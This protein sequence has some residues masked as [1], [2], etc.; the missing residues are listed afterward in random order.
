MEKK[1][2][3]FVITALLCMFPFLANATRMSQGTHE[4]L[5][6]CSAIINPRYGEVEIQQLNQCIK[7]SFVADF[8]LVGLR[9]CNEM[10]PAGPLGIR[11]E[12]YEMI[13]NLQYT[14]PN[15]PKKLEECIDLKLK[16]GFFEEVKNCLKESAD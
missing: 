1:M 7:L 11:L 4:L 5:E 13:A 10:F 14:S 3:T 12:C 15:A 2:K 9:A 8:D 16:K 6:G